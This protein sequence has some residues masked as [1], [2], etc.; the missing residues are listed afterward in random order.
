VG[1]GLIAFLA[2]VE[3]KNIDAGGSQRPCAV[4]GQLF[5]KADLF[6]PCEQRGIQHPEL[7]GHVRK[8]RAATHQTFCPLL[9]CHITS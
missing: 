7:V 5:F 9:D 1:A 3:L 4:I 2:D 8:R 6:L